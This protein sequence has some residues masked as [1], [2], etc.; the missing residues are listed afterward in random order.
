MALQPEKAE[1]A[2]LRAELRHRGRKIVATTVHISE[3]LVFVQTTQSADIGDQVEVELSFPGLLSPLRLEAQVIAHR[4]SSGPGVPGGWSLGFVFRQDEERRDLLQLLEL[5]SDPNLES[6]P[7]QFRVLVVEDSKLVREVF[8]YSIKRYFRGRE[9]SVTVETAA[10]AEEAWERLQDEIFDLAVVD[11]FL[12]SMRGDHLISQM[13]DTD[14]L[15]N[16]PVLAISIGGD[17]AR[18]A[19]LSAGADI[20]LD[21]PLILGDLFGT[22]ERLVNAKKTVGAA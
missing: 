17:E 3:K 11:F 22:L 10:S 9:Q 5:F 13:R 4:L 1:R 21:K 7:K 18:D 20:F 15:A 12:P 19:S 8:I 14:E 6:P 16:M 2:I